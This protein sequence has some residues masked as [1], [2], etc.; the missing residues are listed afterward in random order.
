[1]DKMNQDSNNCPEYVTPGAEAP[2][3]VNGDYISFLSVKRA[4]TY[5]QLTNQGAFWWKQV[6]QEGNTYNQTTFDQG[7]TER[8]LHYFQ[9]RYKQI[10]AKIESLEISPELCASYRWVDAR[11]SFPPKAKDANGEK[12]KVSVEVIVYLSDK[13]TVGG[14]FDYSKGAW[15]SYGISGAK[16]DLQT[17]LNDVRY[18]CYLPALPPCAP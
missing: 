8:L 5:M 12:L 10:N 2:D 18:W 6:S 7:C 3:S 11:S 14:W 1:M 17:Y 16:D 4:T 15:Y 9:S 13:S